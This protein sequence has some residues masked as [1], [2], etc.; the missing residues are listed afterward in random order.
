MSNKIL[1]RITS[2]GECPHYV[3][4]SG[5]VHNCRLVDEVVRDKSRVAPFCPLADYPSRVIADMETT[6][7]GLREPLTYGFGLALLTYV[8][9][10]LKVNVHTRGSSLV[11]PLKDGRKVGLGLDYI[12]AIRVYPFEISFNHGEHS[13]KL[14]PDVGQL[15]E[16]VPPKE[17]QEEELWLHHDVAC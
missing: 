16:S 4:Y 2:C 7:T 13:Y 9:A 1:D 3:Y 5:G 15:R 8:A 17:G 12:T 14:L 6:I 11:V 10:K